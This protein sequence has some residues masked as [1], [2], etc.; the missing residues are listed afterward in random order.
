MAG[1]AGLISAAGVVSRY[2]RRTGDA[3]LVA[4]QALLE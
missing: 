4:D 3:G 2:C 1:L